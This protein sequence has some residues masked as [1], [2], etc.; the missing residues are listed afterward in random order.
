M[1]RSHPANGAPEA[2]RD[3]RATLDQ[4]LPAAEGAGVR[5]GIEP[6]TGNVVADAGRGR[7]LIESRSRRPL[8]GI[9]ID[10]AN[11]VTPSHPRHQG[12]ILPPPSPTWG[13]ETVALHAKDVVPRRLRRGRPGRPG[14]RAWSSPSTRTCPGPCP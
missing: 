8:I 6:E 3:M 4:L 1:W 12:R 9:V 2:W 11:L 5:L 14:L 10:P 13:P 7:R